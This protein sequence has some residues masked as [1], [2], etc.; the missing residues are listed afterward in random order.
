V[1]DP[2]AAEAALRRV[3]EARPAHLEAFQQLSRLLEASDRGSDLASLLEARLELDSIGVDERAALARSG[4]ARRG[5]GWSRSSTRAS[6]RRPTTTP[7]PSSARSRSGSRPRRSAPSG[8][9]AGCVP[10]SVSIEPPT[11]SWRPWSL[12][13]PR[14][15]GLPPSSSG[16]SDSCASSTDRS[17]SR[18]L[19]SRR[20]SCRPAATPRSEPCTWGSCSRCSTSGSTTRFAHS[21]GSTDRRGS[22]RSC[23]RTALA[24]PQGWTIPLGRSPSSRDWL[25]PC[26]GTA[27]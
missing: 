4:E 26:R 13:W 24:S 15:R 20:S 11:R 22:R 6:R 23:L 2:E 19:S 10:S 12:C 18:A 17:R 27:R 16:E 8:R 25:R 5:T 9:S 7:A 21:T 3:L 14:L 1:R